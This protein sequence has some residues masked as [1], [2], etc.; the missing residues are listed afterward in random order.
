MGVY[1]I[2][3][4]VCKLG[5]VLKMENGRFL[6]KRGCLQVGRCLEKEK[7][8]FSGIKGAVS[9]LGAIRKIKKRAFIV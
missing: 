8:A 2:K 7:W 6:Y 9:K 3:G 1:C 5:S 4:A